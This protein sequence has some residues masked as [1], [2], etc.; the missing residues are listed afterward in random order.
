[1][2]KKHFE[3]AAAYLR[4]CRSILTEGE[5]AMIVRTLVDLFSEFNPRFDTDRFRAACD[6]PRAVRDRGAA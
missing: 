5:R 4:D 6:G 2:I 3:W 1:M